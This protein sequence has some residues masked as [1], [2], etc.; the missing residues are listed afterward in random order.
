MRRVVHCLAWVGGWVGV[1]EVEAGDAEEDERKHTGLP[2]MESVGR[3]PAIIIG[4]KVLVLPT[5]S[6]T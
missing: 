4:G 5:P 1:G 6:K 3:L 2:S